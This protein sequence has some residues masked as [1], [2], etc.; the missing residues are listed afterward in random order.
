MNTNT[1]PGRL[2][3]L[4]DEAKLTQQEL[5]DRAKL[6]RESVARYETGQRSPAFA[7]LCK[8]ADALGVPIDA[9]RHEKKTSR[10]SKKSAE[11]P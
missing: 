4:R 5:A 11:T 10:K 1:L 7:A 3:Q 2:R 8:L 9:L 6:T